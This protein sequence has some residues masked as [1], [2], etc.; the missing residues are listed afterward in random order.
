MKCLLISYSDYEYNGRL[1][2][3]V[4]VMSNIS[5]LTFISRNSG[6]KSENNIVINDSYIKFVFKTIKI[7][8]KFNDIDLVLLDNRKSIIPGLILKKHFKKALYILDCRE[9]YLYKDVRKFSS[10]IGCLIEKKGIKKSD[11]ITCANKHRS[12]YMKDYFGLK[13][14]PLVFENRRRLNYTSD[15]QNDEYEFINS[16]LFDDEIRLI[17]TA[18][19][20]LTRMTDV[21]IKNL[22]KI[23]GN[24]RLYLVGKYTAKEKEKF[25]LLIEE[26]KLNNVTIIGRLNQNQLKYIVSKSHIGIVSYHQKDVNNLY[27]ASGKIYE[28]LFE[29]VP[30][31]TT[32]NPTLVDL[33]VPNKIG[34]SSDEFIDAINKVIANYDYYK[35]NV[36]KFISKISIDSMDSE[37]SNILYN[38]IVKYKEK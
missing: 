23:N 15:K 11:I 1:R 32:T 6:L 12:E 20:T 2:E 35:K 38:E 30:V 33:V 16:C 31:V 29:N 36:E 21:L 14:A 13:Y 10:K 7:A 3:L 19:C 5:E 22:K 24:V 34:E 4:K 37:F 8:K 9:L 17:S 25:D 26:Y 28:F 27:C 18:G